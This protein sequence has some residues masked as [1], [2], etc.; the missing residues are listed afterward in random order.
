VKELEL[1]A[2]VRTM[3]G[4]I[5]ERPCEHSGAIYRPRVQVQ[6]YCSR[7]CRNHGLAAEGCAA[8]RAWDAAW[9]PIQTDTRDAEITD[10]SLRLGG[11]D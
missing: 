1:S 6:R 4:A 5:R 11:G 3:P 9:R 7:Q 2:Q 8:R 10:R